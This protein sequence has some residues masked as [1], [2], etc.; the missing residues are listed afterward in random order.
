VNNPAH[1]GL[2][3]LLRPG[4]GALRP[5]L[6]S[7]RRI[8]NGNGSVLDY[9]NYTHFCPP[10]KSRNISV[11]KTDPFSENTPIL[12]LN[13]GPAAFPGLWLDGRFKR[14]RTGND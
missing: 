1:S 5:I 7:L 13:I 4:T 9:V 10:Q 2:R 11:S 3:M 6:R 8:G 14:R 12:A